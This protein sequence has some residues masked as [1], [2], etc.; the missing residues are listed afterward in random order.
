MAA[1]RRVKLVGA[2]LGRLDILSFFLLMF[3][4]RGG[5]TCMEKELFQEIRD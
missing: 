2:M 5:T 3:C 1:E 4:C